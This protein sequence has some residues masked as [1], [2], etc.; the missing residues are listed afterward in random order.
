MS[1]YGPPSFPEISGGTTVHLPRS[2]LDIDEGVIVN[3]LD[4][5]DPWLQLP[6]FEDG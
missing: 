6:V 4:L 5:V 1:T 3:V 2:H